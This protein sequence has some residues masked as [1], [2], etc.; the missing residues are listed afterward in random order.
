[1]S[2]SFYLNGFLHILAISGQNEVQCRDYALVLSI[3][4]VYWDVALMW[5]IPQTALRSHSLIIKFSSYD[6]DNFIITSK[7]HK[8]LT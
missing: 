1:M 6:T 3:Y 7:T 4:H 8:T 5:T 2:E